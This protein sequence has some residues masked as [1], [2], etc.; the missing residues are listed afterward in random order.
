MSNFKIAVSKD[1]KKYNI[2]FKADNESVARERVHKEWYSIL[3]IEEIFDKHQIW[4]TFVFE[5]YKSW[6]LKH[7]KI[8]WN[9]IFKA[10]VK[11]RKD[12]EYDINF[13]YE[14]GDENITYEKK[15][16][17]IEELKEEYNMYYSSW[18][19]EKI[20][21]L[22]DKIKKEKEENKKL[23][24]FYL[25]KELEEVNLLLEKVLLKLEAM[26][27]G[28]SFIKVD[29]ILKDKL[30][31]IY[32]E[33]IKLKKT[34]NISKLREIWE[35][36]LLKIWKIELEELE[37]TKNKDSRVLLIETNK[38]LKKIWSKGQFIEKDRDIV[39]QSKYLLNSIKNIFSEIKVN[40]KKE[41][42]DKES[43]SYVKNLLYLSKYKDYYKE[44]TKTILKNFYKFLYD[45]DLKDEIFLSRSV[46]KQNIVLLK[47][48]EKWVNVSYTF[49]KKWINKFLD[50]FYNFFKLLSKI[51][52]IIIV[53]Y[54]I[55]FIVYFNLYYFISIEYSNYDWIFY[56]IALLMLFLSIKLA[57]SMFFLIINFVF[58]FFIIIFG[59]INF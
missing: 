3:S 25:K 2:V 53:L 46:I 39:Y 31:I 45:K 15:S 50:S 37:K 38:L 10:Y 36:A 44:N 11:L 55:S 56:F 21:E 22:R 51:I 35:L 9:D 27:H 13:I 20:D 6:E 30:K 16:K 33:I 1:G 42:I 8:V 12:L 43:H 26:V 4:D 48:K 14:E 40:R 18:K 29:P 5:G 17:I 57:N 49:L 23:D 52:F 24:N 58:L 7:W 47:A 54:F 34:T 19:K 41:E 59:V 28:T 32:N